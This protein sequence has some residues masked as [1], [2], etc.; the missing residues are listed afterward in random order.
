FWLSHYSKVHVQEFQ[1]QAFT[2]GCLLPG[3][4]RCDD[5]F[6]FHIKDNLPAKAFCAT[7]PDAGHSILREAN[8][9]TQ[10]KG[11]VAR[12]KAKIPGK[13]MAG[14]NLCAMNCVCIL[15]KCNC[16]PFYKCGRTVSAK[17]EKDRHLYFFA[18]RRTEG[19]PSSQTT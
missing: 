6:F 12:R 7:R 8:G 11:S 15:K 17:D 16:E 5:R 9:R 10:G 1:F 18:G 19:N 3:L 4:H 2:D 13:T 14:K